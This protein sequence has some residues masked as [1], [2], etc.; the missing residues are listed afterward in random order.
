[1]S[2]EKANQLVANSNQQME[3][4]IQ[5]LESELAKI[6][7]GRAN[8]SMLDSIN[9]DYYGMVVPLSNVANVSSPDA[10]TI[11]IQPYEKNMFSPIE[12]AIM[13]SNLNLNPQNDGLVIRL[14]IPP[15][16]EQRRKDLCK[17]ARQESE[18]AKVSIRNIRRDVNDAVKKLTKE[19]L[20]EDEAKGLEIKVQQKT[21]S[22]ITQIDKLADTKEKDIMTI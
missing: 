4:A 11:V 6:R 13:M 10:R 9:V 16:T 21:D 15:L 20:S 19:G 18:H 14:I 8:A 7:A 22:F 2:T 1:M 5:H 17:L 3:K 12:K